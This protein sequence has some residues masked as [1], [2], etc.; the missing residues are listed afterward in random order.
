MQHGCS[1][2]SVTVATAYDTLGEAGL[3]HSLN[4]PDCVGVFTNADLL[5]VVAAVLPNTPSI[6]YVVYDGTAP[7]PVLEKLNRAA[8]G[9][10]VKVFTI[11]ELL[12]LG[13]GKPEI[14][15]D[16]KPKTTDTACIMYTS[17]TT[18]NPKGVVIPHSMICGSIAGALALIGHVLSPEEDSF[19]AFLPSA[20]IL[21]YIVELIMQFKGIRIGYGRIKTLTDLS[22]RECLGDLREFKPAIMIGVPAIWETIRK[23]IISKVSKRVSGCVGRLTNTLMCR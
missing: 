8:E 6:R 2:V 21:E 16:R 5:P 3:T 7:A 22:V 19:L 9:A 10:D 15:A 13:K 14:P 4:E 18:G 20:H 11:D 12:A 1:A 17:G 23:G